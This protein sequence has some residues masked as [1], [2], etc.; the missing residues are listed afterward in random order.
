MA[1]I[2]G[3]VVGAAKSGAGYEVVR[4]VGGSDPGGDS[5]PVAPKSTMPGPVPGP[6]ARARRLAFEL[7]ISATSSQIAPIKISR[8]PSAASITIDPA[9]E[10]MDSTDLDSAIRASPVDT[11]DTSTRYSPATVA[12]NEATPTYL[13]DPSVRVSEKLPP[14]PVHLTVIGPAGPDTEMFRQSTSVAE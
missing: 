7:D 8:K 3:G 10:N 14:Q 9:A 13:S 4:P 1:G 11:S 2:T 5:E 6:G 12:S